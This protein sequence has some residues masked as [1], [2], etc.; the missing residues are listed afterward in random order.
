KDAEV[1]VQE[2]VP[3]VVAQRPILFQVVANL[4]SNAA[5]F[6][7]PGVSPRIRIFAQARDGWVRLVVEDNGIGV[8][9]QFRDKLFGVF[10]RLQ[11]ADAYPGTGIGLAIVKRAVERMGGRVGVEPREPRGS[12]FWF[13]LPLAVP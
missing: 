10:E 11:A 13:E 9:P 6:V 8:A 1:V 5:K 12:A 4:L 7:P 2:A 3:K